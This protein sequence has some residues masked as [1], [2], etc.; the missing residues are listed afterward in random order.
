MQFAKRNFVSDGA[1][2][3]EKYLVSENKTIFTRLMLYKIPM[4]L[5]LYH[6]G[7]VVNHILRKI[8]DFSNFTMLQ[9]YATTVS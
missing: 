2:I 4:L 8:A 5:F 7:N 9:C 6:K 1:C 3:E